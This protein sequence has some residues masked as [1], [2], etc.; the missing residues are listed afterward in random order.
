MC[1]D[2]FTIKGKGHI[3]EIGVGLQHPSGLCHKT[4]NS[5][6]SG[7]VV[8]SRPEALAGTNQLNTMR[9]FAAFAASYNH[10]RCPSGFAVRG[11]TDRLGW[12]RL[13]QRMETKH[14]MSF[15]SDRG[16]E[17]KIGIR[18]GGVDYILSRHRTGLSPQAED[19]S[20]HKKVFFFQHDQIFAKVSFTQPKTYTLF[21]L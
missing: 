14:E 13:T 16:M 11:R 3:T 19:E 8:Q 21:S 9:S 10:R 18:D 20:R 17:Q 15:I 1:L 2:L 4:L 12:I 5:C 7:G 6:T